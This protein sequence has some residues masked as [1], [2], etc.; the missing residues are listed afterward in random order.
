MYHEWLV[1]FRLFTS[2][3]ARVDHSNG[4]NITN[5]LKIHQSFKYKWFIVCVCP[6][7]LIFLSFIRKVRTFIYAKKELRSSG[8]IRSILEQYLVCQQGRQCSLLL[9]ANDEARISL[10]LRLLMSY[11][12]IYN[13]ISSLRVNDLTLI[14]LTWRK[15]RANNAS[16]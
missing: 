13:N 16:K 10:T 14:L 9:V 15:S 8:N 2:V 3:A 4:N 11:I 1:K 5:S 7:T 6:N 12:Y